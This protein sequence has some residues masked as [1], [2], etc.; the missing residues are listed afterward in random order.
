MIGHFGV[1]KTSLVKRYVEGI[2]SEEYLTTIGVNIEKK[3]VTI[4]GIGYNLIIWDIAG[5][6]ELEK[7]NKSYLLGTHGVL[8]V[9]DCGREATYNKL[10]EDVAALKK[11]I[12]NAAISV[13][14]NKK[15]LV[16]EDQIAAI[17]SGYGENITFTSAKND[18]NVEKVFEVLTEKC[19]NR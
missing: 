19:I 6:M 8:Y 10:T 2:F 18:S 12:P 14:G 4:D 9:F 1:G 16:T 15:D 11:Q 5:E 17:A 13:V 7:I 3:T